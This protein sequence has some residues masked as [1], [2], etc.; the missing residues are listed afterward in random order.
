MAGLARV[1]LLLA[2]LVAGVLFAPSPAAAAAVALAG[3]ALSF[4]RRGPGR[5]VALVAVAFAFGA[6]NAYVRLPERQ[7]LTALARTVPSCAVHGRTL[8]DAGG[9]GVLVAIDRIECEGRGPAVDAGTAFLDDFEIAAGRAFSAEGW[10]IPLTTEPFDRARSHAGAAASFRVTTATDEGALPG[11]HRFAGAVR[12]GLEV[13][14]APLG[15]PGALLRGLAIGDTAGLDGHTEELLRRSGLAHL[16]AVSGSNVA[17][18]LGAVAVTLRNASMLVR[19]GV[20]AA[21]LVAFLA[22]VGPDASVLRAAGM[23]AV[24]LVALAAGRRA[25]PLHALGLALVTVVALRPGIVYSAGLHL[26]VAAT[27]GIVL[28]AGPIAARLRRLPRPAALA[29]GATSA[30]Q[31]AVTPLLAGVFGALPVAGLPAN[32]LAL[33]A[34]APATVLT[35]AAAAAAPWSG[36]VAA[37]LA[38][39]ASPFAA[40]ILRVG[41]TFG[42]PAWASLSVP[43]SWG[44]VLA[45]PV[46]AAAARRIVTLSRP[47]RRLDA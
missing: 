3:A 42:E 8:E 21:T 29:L 35:L 46:V 47:P 20:C 1:W 2:G 37:A 10:L 27:L 14:A 15:A 5:A 39:A 19:V 33:P 17:I 44:V 38:R 31:I 25:E 18:L 4:R 22:V 23:G 36:A 43:R 16:L 24:A 40:W 26:S 30:A 12:D 28:W 45:V 13:A 9:L 32:L 7:P 6:T 41:E 11:M 34:V